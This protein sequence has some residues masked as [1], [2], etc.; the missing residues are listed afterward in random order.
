MYRCELRLASAWLPPEFVEVFLTPRRRAKNSENLHKGFPLGAG[1]PAVR[2][3]SDPSL[4]PPLQ[5]I[6]LH[7]C[8]RPG[9][10]QSYV[11]ERSSNAANGMP[12]HAINAGTQLQAERPVVAIVDD[13]QAV[14]SSLKFSLELE[15]FAARTF[16]AGAELL[17]ARDLDA[18]R[19]FVIDQ[20]MPRMSGMELADA[21]RARQI[22]TPIILIIS[23]P[24]AALSARATKARIPIVEKPLLGNALV[25]HIREACGLD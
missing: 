10:W 6:D 11:M 12:D 20:R 13:D 22:T 21:L 17:S 7:Q 16:R 5:G 1:R 9:L 8:G 24:N 14:C 3:A 23:H 2:A 4:T 25:E 15:G 18:Y 19:C